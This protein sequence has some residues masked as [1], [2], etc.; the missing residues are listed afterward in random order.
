MSMVL[1]FISILSDIYILFKWPKTILIILVN[2]NNTAI[3]H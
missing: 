2:N 1:G 3:M